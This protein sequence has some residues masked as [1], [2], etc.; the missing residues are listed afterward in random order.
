MSVAPRAPITNPLQLNVTGNESGQMTVGVV[1]MIVRIE[2][3]DDAPILVPA[4]G[5]N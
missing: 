4:S 3:T 1:T 2:R 5:E